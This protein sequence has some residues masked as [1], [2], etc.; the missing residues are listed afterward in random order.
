[1]VAEAVFQPTAPVV[2][3]VVERVESGLVAER[4]AVVLGVEGRAEPPEGHLDSQLRL[5][6]PRQPVQVVEAEPER[7]VC[8]E[9]ALIFGPLAVEIDAVVASLLQDRPAAAVR[10][11]VAPESH[12][13]RR[14]HLLNGRVQTPTADDVGAVDR[15]ARWRH[16]K[17]AQQTRQQTPRAAACGSNHLDDTVYRQAAPLMIMTSHRSSWLRSVRIQLTQT[18]APKDA[19]SL[20]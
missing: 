4:H 14:E 11:E 16:C 13:G 9:A 19:L 6:V 17:G 18:T 20:Q 7:V 12:W 10:L 5:V 2:D 1:M 15:T 8:A 3:G